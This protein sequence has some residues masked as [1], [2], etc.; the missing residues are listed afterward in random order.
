[1]TG[2]AQPDAVRLVDK[3]KGVFPGGAEHRHQALVHPQDVGLL[4]VDR[5]REAVVVRHREEDE[6]RGVQR[7]LSVEAGIGHLE[8]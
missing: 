5:G 3:I 8:H 1:M 2:L 4:A 6:V 7:D